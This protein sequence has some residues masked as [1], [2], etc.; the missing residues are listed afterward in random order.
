MINMGC[1]GG[2]ARENECQYGVEIIREIAA[3]SL[4][5]ISRFKAKS[6]ASILILDLGF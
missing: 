1:V 2:C 6:S 5:E 4:R 3:T